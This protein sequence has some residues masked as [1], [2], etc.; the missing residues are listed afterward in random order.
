MKMNTLPTVDV[1][2]PTYHPDK[3]EV[4]KLLIRLTEQTV[5]PSHLLII[6]TEEKYWDAGITKNIPEAEVFHISKA[7]FDHA[8]TRNMGAGFSNADYILFMTQDALPADDR[9]IADLAA[10]LSDPGVAAAYARQL[11]SDE[12]SLGEKF[13]RGFNYPAQ[14]C[15]K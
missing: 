10:A 2:I 5:K 12:A 7:N 14:S 8:G 1:V 4:R 3:E 15:V 13:S 9:L 6:N 11:P